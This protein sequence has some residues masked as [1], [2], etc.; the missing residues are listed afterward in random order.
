[1]PFDYK[2]VFLFM[3]INNIFIILLFLYFVVNKNMQHW[4]FIFFIVGKSFQTIG[5]LGVGL[6]EQIP[7]I[8]SVHGSNFFLIFCFAINAF[9]VLSYDGIFRK[10]LLYYFLALATLFYFGFLIC[11]EHNAARI[12][13][14][15]LASV[16]F[17]GIAAFVMLRQ[18]IKYSFTYLISITFIV[19]C[20]FQIVRALL[21]YS[22]GK[23]YMFFEQNTIDSVFI[24][25]ATLAMSATSVGFL[26]LLL[27]VNARTIVKKN[28]II[29]KERQQL[30][31]L[32]QTKNKFFSIIA[33]DLRGPLGSINS[34]LQLM[35]EQNNNKQDKNQHKTFQL[36]YQTSKNTF[37]LLENLLT[38]ARTHSGGINYNPINS[39]ISLLVKNNLNLIQGAA[40]N[41]KISVVNNI[42]ESIICAFDI[43]MI[44]TVFRNLVNNAIKYTNSY[45]TITISGEKQDNFFKIKI[46]DTGTG[47]GQDMVNK[48][49][50]I[51]KRNISKPGTNGEKGTGLGLI[52]CKEFVVKH[53]GEIQVESEPDKGS[54]FSFT[55]PLSK[56]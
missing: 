40:A 14:Q 13:I 11:S 34:L 27:E 35:A 8:L 56:T 10:R 15:N 36:L 46:K 43:A 17:F 25:I 47:M 55:L 20:L 44:D 49:F 23:G 52:L 48:L 7:E 16:C 1:M 45:G 9:A 30:Q 26:L 41:K 38:W 32:N 19:F 12:V 4:F 29:E 24:V 51:D 5:F 6:R 42:T 22:Y 50:R 33:H 54:I 28:T 31:N 37:A 2:S 21:I 53:G 18:K 3:I 39:D